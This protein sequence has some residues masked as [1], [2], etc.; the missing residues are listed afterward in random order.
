MAK[1]EAATRTQLILHFMGTDTPELRRTDFFHPVYAPGGR[2][3]IRGK[4]PRA[5]PGFRSFQWSP[6]VKVLVAYL[7]RCAAW[8]RRGGDRQSGAE[9]PALEGG[10]GT[11]AASLN[12]ALSK[13]NA[14]VC[15]M[16]GS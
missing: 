14:W 15:D 7:L 4:K 16:F 5:H 6:A 9:C 11:P 12:W 3:T 10:P 1:L 2:H 13:Q 8:A